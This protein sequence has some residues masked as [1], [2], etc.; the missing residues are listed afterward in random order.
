MGVLLTKVSQARTSLNQKI[1]LLLFGLMICVL[2]L[3][4]CLRV[5][6]FAISSTQEYRNLLS[7]RQHGAY[8]I[9]CL[10]ES[11]TAGEYPQFLE[12][13]LNKSNVNIKFSVINKGVPGAG[14]STI[15]SLL[16]DN[17]KKYHPDMVVAMIG[18][19][20]KGA[21]MPYK[22]VGASHKIVHFIRALKVYK[23][24]RF[25]LLRVTTKVKESGVFKPVSIENG[26]GGWFECIY[27]EFDSLC[28]AQ[29]EVKN[30]AER[31]LEQGIRSDSMDCATCFSLGEFYA[32]N[33]KFNQ[34][35]VFLN[36]YLK[37]CPDNPLAYRLLATVYQSQKKITQAEVLLAGSIRRDF[38]NTEAYYE[39]GLAYLNQ[40]EFRSAKRIFKDIIKINPFYPKSYDGLFNTCAF[41]GNEN[42][43][44]FFFLNLYK[45]N[46]K[47][48]FLL[49]AL[50]K[51]CRQNN[52]FI[53]A[54]R[55]L[56]E[57]L[58]LNSDNCGTIIELAKVY[59][60]QGKFAVAEELLKNALN[61]CADDRLLYIV[62][63][64][65]YFNQ[66]QISQAEKIIR[67]A[68]EKY[69]KDDVIAGFL[70]LIILKNNN[71]VDT[72][73]HINMATKL[74]QI[75][76]DPITKSN[77]LQIKKI[78]DKYKIQL[79]SVQYPMRDL[80]PLKKMLDSESGIIFVDNS[81]VFKEA[82]RKD[83]FTAYFMDNFGGD[84]GHCTK[85]G[86][87]LLAKNIASVIVIDFFKK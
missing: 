26:N 13:E 17:I 49:S 85:K 31:V 36:K 84:F 15:A 59:I 6:G 40:G 4:V 47:N 24:I 63:A 66:G 62:L 30:T 29:N 71:F 23:L 8:R 65:A 79:V 51:F 9:M 32:K 86:N 16:E 27:R 67:G 56:R 75:Y 35:E 3:E 33:N 14:T 50:G 43:A 19:N 57:A 34:A 52:D 81:K 20:D 44:G 69:P 80:A 76:Y 41:Q 28:Y 74:R 70:T 58:V 73:K 12:E 5:A 53:G 82:V 7:I 46:L 55:Y 87:R 68:L 64:N 83:G 21:H 2:S 45:N 78:L 18:V 42:K 10:G 25:V 38:R 1:W 77:Y 22:E 11:T 48:Q 54:E 61:K 37:M 72:K 39:L 60:D